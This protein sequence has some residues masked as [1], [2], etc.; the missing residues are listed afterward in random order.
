LICISQWYQQGCPRVQLTRGSGRVKILVNYGRSGLVENLETCVFCYFL[1][2]MS[3]FVVHC[4][5][6]RGC[7]VD[8]TLHFKYKFKMWNIIMLILYFKNSTFGVIMS[9]SGRVGSKI[10]RVGLCRVTKNGPVDISAQL[11]ISTGIAQIFGDVG[12]HGISQISVNL[13]LQHGYR[14]CSPDQPLL[15]NLPSTSVHPVNSASGSPFFPV[16]S[17]QCFETDIFS[18]FRFNVSPCQ[19]MC[20]RYRFL[21]RHEP[22]GL[23]VSQHRDEDI[24]YL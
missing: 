6:F 17:A 21:F 8:E 4:A 15:P 7:H 1:K 14:M 24:G 10:W 12:L 3:Y 2:Y 20:G 5:Y 18:F 22:S 19:V 23:T 11:Y 16:F 13:T 9:W